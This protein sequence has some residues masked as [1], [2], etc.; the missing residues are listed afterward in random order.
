VLRTLIGAGRESA[1]AKWKHDN[2]DLVTA[3]DKEAESEDATIA[4]EKAEPAAKRACV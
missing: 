2:P 4:E 3:S 1:Y